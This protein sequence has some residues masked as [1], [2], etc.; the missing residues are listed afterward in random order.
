MGFPEDYFEL[1]LDVE[2]TDTGLD[3]MLHAAV[4]ARLAQQDP[5]LSGTPQDLVPLLRSFHREAWTFGAVATGVLVLDVPG[6]RYVASVRTWLEDEGLERVDVR[7]KPRPRT[8][9]LAEVLAEP[10]PGDLTS[11]QVQVVDLPAGPAV[12]VGYRA[13]DAEGQVEG[14]EPTV[15]LEVLEH[16]FLLPDLAKAFVLQ[17]RTPNLVHREDLEADLDLI[18]GSVRLEP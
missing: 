6:T 13:D 15:V 14:A 8:K 1:P 12:R 3:A 9:R 5:E 11:R 10:R 7:A 4:E 2:P 16:W 18:A 17:G